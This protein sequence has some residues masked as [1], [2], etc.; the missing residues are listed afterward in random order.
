MRRAAGR[1]GTQT[2]IFA[3]VGVACTVAYAVLFLLL[4][5][6]MPAMAANAFALLLTAIANTAANRRYTFGVRGRAE[7]IRHHVQALLVF[8][9]GLVLTSASLAL[10]SSWAPGASRWVEVLVLTAANLTVTVMRF[11]AMRVW[12]LRPSDGELRPGRGE[13]RS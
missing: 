13:A 12:I 9:V 4:R 1:L 10:L 2:A 8:G 5:H 3:S 6:L 11:V 7:A